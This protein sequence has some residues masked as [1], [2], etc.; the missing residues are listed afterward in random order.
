MHRYSRGDYC[1]AS[2]TPTG[3]A[4]TVLN[5]KNHSF[6]LM[7]TLFDVT[8]TGSG[9]GTARIGGKLDFNGTINAALDLDALPWLAIPNILPLTRGITA[10]YVSPIAFIQ[11]PTIVEKFHG[12]SAVDSEVQY[13]FDVKMDAHSGL[14]IFPPIA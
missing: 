11:V 2:V 1:P 4:T 14:L 3:G 10:F 9:G 5:I 8:G 7:A 13:S 6:D 12:Q